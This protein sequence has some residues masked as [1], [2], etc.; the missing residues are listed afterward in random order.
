V[1]HIEKLQTIAALAI[2]PNTAEESWTAIMH[3]CR[4]LEE[5]I[6][7]QKAL[8][9]SVMARFAAECSAF[10]KAQA[11]KPDGDGGS[12]GLKRRRP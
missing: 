4:I 11:P 1:N 6:A 5:E 3:I 9:N 7:Q 12:S 2:R 8:S 10:F